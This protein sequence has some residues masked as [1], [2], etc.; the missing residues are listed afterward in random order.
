MLTRY[1][2]VIF[3]LITCIAGCHTTTNAFDPESRSFT[4][5]NVNIV[6][7]KAGAILPGQN[8]CVVD[9]IITQVS[10]NSCP[11]NDLTEIDGKGGYLTPG[12]IDMHVHTFEKEGL[13]FTLS[14][15][16]T[17]VR[18]M[19]GVSAQLKWR[20]D[21]EAGTMLSSTATVSSP[22]ISGYEGAVLH[23][24]LS[25]AEDARKAV[26][27]YHAQGYDLIKAYN[28]LNPQAFL[29]LME[30][31]R[32]LGIPVAK[33][34]PDVP[35][36]FDIADFNDVQSFEHVENI[37]YVALDRK[38]NIENLAPF[39]E[40]AKATGV[41]I[42]PTVNIFDQLTRLSV[43]KEAFVNQLPQHYISSIVKMEDKR[44]QVKR[45]LETTEQNANY[46]QQV[47]NFLLVMTKALHD[48]DIPLLIGTDSGNLLSP[49]G[50]A[51]HNEMR[52]F[53]DAGIDSFS[54]LKAATYN[55]A[56]ALNLEKQ[57]GQ[58][59]ERFYADFILSDHDPTKDLQQLKMPKAVAKRGVWLN[60]GDLEQLRS[61]AKDSKSLWSE[62]R[63]YSE[64]LTR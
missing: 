39:I 37:F 7:V 40:K 54:I 30:E 57:I 11:R 8:V 44:N 49:H 53:S 58:I 60:Q 15:G 32:K 23:H 45:W 25:S 24:G 26:T 17:H 6:D 46:N 56:K 52:L 19:N 12:L 48:A 64:M 42:T 22:I 9:S 28:N 10:K 38:M 63:V 27:K 31:S 51:T 36:S 34:G 59:K 4:L 3:G 5:K 2:L 33:D 21:A 47:F 14:H 41:P 16:V 61:K 43:E 1:K 29:A 50:L 62:L 20:D 55:A 13:M 18:L 35:T